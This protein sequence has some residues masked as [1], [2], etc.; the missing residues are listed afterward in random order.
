MN[1][2]EKL[3]HTACSSIFLHLLRTLEK[4]PQ[5]RA[6][7]KSRLQRAMQDER[8]IVLGQF[9]ERRGKLFYFLE[10]QRTDL[11]RRITVQFQLNDAIVAPK[12]ASVPDKFS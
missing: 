11:V 12:R 9:F 4:L 6:S 1:P 3:A 2:F 5:I 7:G 10:R 8:V